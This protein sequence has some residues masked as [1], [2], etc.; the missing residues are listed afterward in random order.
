MH[1]RSGKKGRV[2]RNQ[3]THTNP[4]YLPPPIAEGFEKELTELVSRL[5]ESNGFKGRYLAETWKSK[6]RD[7]K[8]D[9]SAKQRE[10][11]A[12]TKWLSQ[13]RKNSATN[14]R[15]QL[16]DVDF[17]WVT[18]DR[19]LEKSREFVTQ[20]L[21]PLRY[22][23]VLWL[24]PGHTNGASTRIKR[25]PNAAILKHAGKAHVS[26]TAENHWHH[27]VKFT[28]LED[29]RT[30]HQESSV[31]FTVPKATEID[32]VACKE[33]EIN[34]Y[35]Q[36]SIGSHI[37]RRLR[38]KGI[39]LNDQT[40]N[41]DLARQ[42]LQLGLATID[43]SSASDSITKQ[44][45][46]ELLPFEWWSL[47]DDL[48]VKTV[49]VKGDTHELEMF[50]SMGNG[51]T[52]E[53]ESL[54]FWAL[55]RAVAFFS[56]KKGKIS[57]YGDDIIVPTTI[58]RRL[59]RIFSW[60]GFKVNQTKSFWS[61]S[62]RESC[63][64]HYHRGIDVTPFYLREPVS[65]KTDIIRLL[66]QLLLWDGR[67]FGFLSDPDIITFHM[68]WSE[69]IPRTLWGGQDPDSPAAL[70]TGCR[71]RCRFVPVTEKVEFPGEYGLLAWLTRRRDID[72]NAIEDDSNVENELD[73]GSIL[74]LDVRKEVRLKIRPQPPY[75]V[76]A[77][78]DPWIIPRV[79]PTCPDS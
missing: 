19:F 2:S 55:A 6:Y 76:R 34:M 37:R 41:Q 52:F 38:L 73:L 57:V 26:S 17:G 40:I 49:N 35:L 20:V 3:R 13:E 36:R 12:I 7:P 15:I 71:P 56:R 67:D 78:W 8:G 53:L 58:A 61:G 44:L 21:G 32:R 65:R 45:V 25:G 68:K 27:S 28:V 77:T 29:Q 11:A 59:A 74:S 69:V 60:L 43:L 48:R 14:R 63:G 33:P 22:P 72:L 79:T 1:A 39:D 66:N 62:F 51:F 23:A 50:S 46:F 30:Q 5:S 31:L 75:A 10:E 9:I 4:D 64:K 70:V 16:G 54:L 24:A 47:L 18:S 42:A